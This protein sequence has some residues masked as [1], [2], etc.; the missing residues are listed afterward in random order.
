MTVLSRRQA[1]IGSAGAAALSALPSLARAGD[2][3]LR[4]FYPVAVSGPLTKII[5]EYA[6][7][8]QKE[9]PGIVIKPVYAGDYVQTVG[10]ALTAL[11]GGDAPELA[12]LQASDILTMTDEKA[13]IPF[14]DFVKTA[15]DKTWFNGFYPA[16][17]ENARHDGKTYGIPFQRSTPVLYWNKDAFKDAGLDPEK[18]P[19]TWEEMVEFGKKL[20]K[21]D[22][23]GNVT[24]YG[25]EIPSDGNTLWLFTGLSTA[26]DIRLVNAEGNRTFF[27]DPKVIEAAQYDVDLSNKY[28]I[29]PPGI[30]SW[31]GAPKEF[32]EKRLAMMFHTT[33]NLTNVR[34]NATFAYGVAMLPAKVHRGAPTGGGN[35]YMFSGL[36]PEKQAAAYAFVRWMTTP[37]RAAEWSINTGYVATSAAA[38]ETAAMKKFIADVPQ[39]A[40]ARDQ[41]PFAVSEV[42]CHE[43]QRIAKAF[44]DNMQA[45]LTGSKTVAVAMADT[46][47][48]AE[49]I[50]KAYR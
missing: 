35:F 27:D 21:K 4:F 22:A 19:A 48:E 10:K 32:L 1:L 36:S 20:T 26:N 16:F 50:L 49:R 15:E 30:T 2:I 3:E 12:I 28:A 41:L 47:A 42:T 37:E 43:G 6:A 9:H 38:Y 14:D 25:I 17:M 24:Q 7:Q 40:V 44:G 31:G 39:A 13:V 18:A 34:K 45:A 33:G 5:E 29:Q 23:S 8:F 46:Q 11:K